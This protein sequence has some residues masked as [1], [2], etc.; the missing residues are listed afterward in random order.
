MSDSD[1]A[2]TRLGR[3]LDRAGVAAVVDPGLRAYMLHVYNYMVLGVAITGCTALATYLLAVT[4]D[5]AV[6]AMRLR[7]GLM[8]TDFGRVVFVGPLKWVVI[9]LPLVLV[10]VLS[11]SVERMRPALAQI[12]FWAYAGLIGVTFAAFFLVFTHTSIVRVFF[13][14]AA[15]FGALSLWGYGT[16]RDL[17]GIGSFLIMGL[18]G[19]VLAGIAALLFAGS[20]LQFVISGAGVLV[21]AGI[22]AWD[23][24]RLK[25]EY[26]YR[27]AQGDV[28]ER[29]AIMGALSLYLNFINLFTL[30]LQLLGQR[31]Q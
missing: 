1:R 4:D 13:I 30:L 16:R 22:T 31:D 2:S 14:T 25:N 23:T 10:F 27:G 12:M 21:F 17:S 8:L 28:A 15:S 6:A 24:Q 5:P 11:S 7:D 3:A 26:L 20:R 29:A 19:L 18:C 9:L